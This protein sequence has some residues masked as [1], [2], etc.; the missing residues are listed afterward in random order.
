[1][2]YLPVTCRFSKLSVIKIL[3]LLNTSLL[4]FM[5]QES[6][7][8]FSKTVKGSQKEKNNKNF[9]L[10]SLKNTQ[11]K[12]SLKPGAGVKVEPTSKMGLISGKYHEPKE[13]YGVNLASAKAEI[14]HVFGDTFFPQ[15]LTSSNIAQCCHQYYL[16]YHLLLQTFLY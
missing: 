10:K 9:V 6:V 13:P 2:L 15:A 3:R 7:L 5:D 11:K 8:L 4:Y 12:I 14:R 1:M 16:H